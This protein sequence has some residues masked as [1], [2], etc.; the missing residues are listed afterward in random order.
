MRSRYSAYTLR[1]EDYLR[2]TW[3]QDT[4]PASL[5]FDHDINRKWLGL[6]IKHAESTGE[7]TATVEFIAR[8]KDGGNKAERLHEISRFVQLQGRWYYLDGDFVR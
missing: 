7:N 2:N 1:L 5:D 3:H 6:S 4:R 8:Y